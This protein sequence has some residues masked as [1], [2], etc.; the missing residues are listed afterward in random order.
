MNR[1]LTTFKMCVP[2][3]EYWS[4]RLVNSQFQHC[5]VRRQVCQPVLNHTSIGAFITIVDRGGVGYAATSDLTPAGLADAAGHAQRWARATANHALMPASCVPRPRG[6]GQYCTPVA[7]PWDALSLTGK[8][9]LLREASDAL[10]ADSR[11]VDWA[12]SLTW[13]QT[14]SLLAN[15]DGAQIEQRFEWVVP[16]LSA[17]ANDGAHTQRR[18]CG[19]P[20]LARQGGLEHLEALDLPAVA[21]TVA[22]EA[23]ALL[24]A[25]NCPSG[26]MDIVLLPGQ[27]ALQVHESIG[28]PLELDRILGDERNYAGRSFVTPEMFGRYRYG[29]E[30]LN[31]SFD[32]SHPEQLASYAFD[33]EGTPSGRVYLIRDGVLERALGGGCSQARAKLPGVA[34]AR[35][36]S[37]N[38]PPIDRMANLNLEPG[39][40]D[41]QALIASIE[42]GVLMDTNRSWSIDDSRNKFQ[43]GC[44]YGRIIRDGELGEVVRDPNYRGTSA[45]FWRSLTKVGDRGTWRMMGTL[46][47]GKGEPNQLIAVGHAVPAC[48]FTDV[49]VFGAQ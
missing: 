13:Q 37:W 3:A 38:R 27:M 43:F 16:E 26:R 19:A 22:R 39:E 25:R 28:H 35:A 36:S 40:S 15:C 29:S 31:V 32:P 14:D 6:N 5:C 11:I 49:D 20:E 44:E 47:C 4:L 2:K 46:S 8:F 34:C 33:D 23:I 45:T 18:S 17:V 21:G 1:T 9:A 24:S 30:G 48:A 41:L 42:R 12:A 10:K 7:Q